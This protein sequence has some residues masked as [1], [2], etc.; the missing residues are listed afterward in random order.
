MKQG[1]PVGA[2]WSLS[3]HLIVGSLRPEGADG[4]PAGG[5]PQWGNP[6]VVLLDE[7]ANTRVIWLV[8][9]GTFFWMGISMIP[10]DEAKCCWFRDVVTLW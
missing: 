8:V 7:S 6:L 10:A 1:E 9:T 4:R 2:T 3:K 5:V